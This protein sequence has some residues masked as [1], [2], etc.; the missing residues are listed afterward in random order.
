MKGG[1]D[2]ICDAVSNLSLVTFGFFY[3][4][5]FYT[6]SALKYFVQN[7]NILFLTEVILV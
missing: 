7:Q 5:K 4:V 1:M 6:A 2:Y 3:S